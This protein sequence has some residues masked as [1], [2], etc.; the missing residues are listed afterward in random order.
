M[1]RFHILSLFLVL[2]VLFA[3]GMLF[4]RRTQAQIGGSA[5]QQAEQTAL[6]A[7]YPKMNISDQ[8]LHLSI[9]GQTMGQTVGVATNSKGHVF[10]YSRSQNQGIARG[11][12]AAML[13]EFDENYKFVKE[14]GPNN[15]GE[16][17]AHAVRVDKSDNVWQ[18]DEGSGMVVKYNP[19][20]QSIFWLGRTPEAI[21]YLQS[22]L[23]ILHF[24]S[25]NPPT[26]D[27]HPKGRVGEF[28]RETDVTWDP[29]GD[30]FVSDGYGNSRVVKISSEGQWEKAVGTYGTGE[31]EF[32]TPHGIT[33]DSQGNIYVADRGNRRI[34][35]YDSDLNFKKT[36]T[37]VGAPWS[38]CVTNT[39]PQYM[40]SGDGTTGKLFKMDMTGKVL[41]MAVTGQDHGEEN[42][43][44][45]IHA[46]D[47]RTPNV[48]YIGSASMWDVQK[49]TI[50]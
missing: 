38:L 24:A 37:G 4:Q 7:N 39:S 22:N 50:R 20:G 32:R 49:V 1:K 40:F 25:P 14:W 8:Y 16:S 45:L 12:R 30:I 46:L 34:Q 15:Y 10:V 21:G 33:A 42:T 2:G 41:G 47:C 18:V 36:I 13:W 5:E 11:G 35:V 28:D 29:Q 6:E 9:P 44:D 43:G 17:F 48:V 27:M 19:E 26:K 3:V 23:E 31:N